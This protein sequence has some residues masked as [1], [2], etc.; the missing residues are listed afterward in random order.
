MVFGTFD[1]F[2]AGHR[3]FLRQAGRRGAVTAVIARDRTVKQ[4]KGHWPKYS[5]KERQKIVQKSGLVAQAV[6]GSLGDKYKIIQIYQPQII[7]LGYDQK[8]FLNDLAMKLCQMGLKDN[9]IIRLPAYQPQKYKSSLL[10]KVG[11]EKFRDI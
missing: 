4:V 10:R 11:D 6:L 1:I 9:K 2:H 7:A 3:Y 8:F 5:E